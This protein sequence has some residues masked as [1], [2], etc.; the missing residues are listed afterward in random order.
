[1]AHASSRTSLQF[2]LKMALR[3]SQV[4]IPSQPTTPVPLIMITGYLS[5]THVYTRNRYGQYGQEWIVMTNQ[6]LSPSRSLSLTVHTQ[7]ATMV[8]LRL[9]VVIVN[10]GALLACSG[11]V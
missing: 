3:M 8:A 1:M 4:S 9:A 2:G 7:E 5:K 11:Q 6:P 10:A